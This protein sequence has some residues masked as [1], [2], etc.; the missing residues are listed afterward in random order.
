M[1][2]VTFPRPRSKMTTESGDE[3]PGPL[4]SGLEFFLPTH[5]TTSNCT[6]VFQKLSAPGVLIQ[7]VWGE[8][9]RPLGWTPPGSTV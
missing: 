3:N 8:G 9:G 2:K 4:T 6:G 7:Q 1:G 5:V